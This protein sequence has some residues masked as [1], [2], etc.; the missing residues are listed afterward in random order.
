MLTQLDDSDWREAFGYAGEPGTEAGDKRHP[1]RTICA[2]DAAVPLSPF[3]REDVAEIIG[4]APGEND[5]PAW[6]IAGRLTDG[7]WFYLEAGCD[8]TGW[9][10]Q[11]GGTAVVSADRERLIRFGITPEER[12]RLGLEIEKP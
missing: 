3:T 11:A 12:T 10:C 1:E 4:M 8:Y 5:G 6:V 9:D 2:E 7:R